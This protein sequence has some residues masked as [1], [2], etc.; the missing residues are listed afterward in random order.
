VSFLREGLTQIDKEVSLP[1]IQ[2]RSQRDNLLQKV[3]NKQPNLSVPKIV[4][5]CKLS[6]TANTKVKCDGV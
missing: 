4:K 6:K 2:T 1:E 3:F 5:K